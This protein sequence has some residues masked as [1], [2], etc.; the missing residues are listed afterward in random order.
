M[1]DKEKQ[2][3]KDADETPDEA[4]DSSND[5][6]SDTKEKKQDSSNK[7][8][9]KRS[10]RSKKG[11]RGGGR[12]KSEFDQEIIDVRRVTRVVAGGRRFSFSVSAVVGNRKGKVGVGVGKANDISQAIGKAMNDA[13]KNAVKLNLDE[14][15][16][17]PFDLEGKHCASHVEMRP[18]PGRGVVAGSSVRDVVQLAGIEDVSTKLLSRTKNKLNNARAAVNALKKIE[19]IKTTA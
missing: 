6:S 7:K 3:K 12:R 4:S 13:K 10:R 5:T 17:I 19:R 11:R 18:A 2:E 14:N 1:T 9:K 16:S 8:K 15:N